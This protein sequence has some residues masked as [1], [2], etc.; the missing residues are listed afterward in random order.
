MPLFTNL[1]Y[2]KQI[3]IIKVH[4]KMRF[5]TLLQL[6]ALINALGHSSYLSMV[7][8]RNS[9]NRQRATELAVTQN[10]K[11]KLE[12]LREKPKDSNRSRRLNRFVSYHN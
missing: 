2:K 8:I 12:K 1:A 10:L 7:N 11:K 4:H 6:L 5:Y 9:I 3:F